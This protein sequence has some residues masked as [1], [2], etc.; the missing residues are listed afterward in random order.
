MRLAFDM[1]SVLQTALK[2]GIDPEGSQVEHNGK[3]VQINTAAY[4]YE[5]AINL[6][7]KA[8]EDTGCVP[9]D[10]ILVF[11]GKD[12]KRRRVM[13]DPTYKANRGK[14]PPEE[15]IQFNSLKDMM[16][17][18]WRKLGAICV[19]QDGV[20]G[21]DVLGWLAKH[22]EEDLTIVTNDGDMS[23]LNGVN[24]HG[25]NILVRLNKVTGLNKYGDFDFKL[26]T[27]YKALVGD[28]NDG[29]KGVVGFGDAAWLDL[30][31]KYGDDGCFELMA[32]IGAGKRDE[33]AQIAHDNK[34]KLLTKITDQWDAATKCLKLTKLHPEWVHTPRVQLVWEPGF[35]HGEVN[36]ER[37]RKWAAKKFLV[38]ADNYEEMYE[39]LAKRMAISR[40]PAFDIESSQP[41]ESDEWLAAQGK[42]DGVD[43]LGHVLTG[44]SITFGR[45]SQN[46]YYVCV[47]HK[48]TKNVTMSQ[49]RKMIELQFSRNVVIQN[50]FFELSV[51]HGAQ[52]EDGTY[53]RDHWKKYGERGFIP[54]I[55]DTKLEGSYVNENM[56]LGLKDRSKFYLGYEQKTYEETVTKIIDGVPVKHKMNELTGEEV[57]DYGADDTM[58]TSGL[59]NF[60]K[61]HMQLDHHW[62]V[63]L[64]TEI[65]A[66]YI[67]AKSFV[68]GMPVSI[69]VSKRL[70]KKDD[71]VYEESWGIVRKYLIEKGWDGTVPPVFTSELT[72]KDI[73]FAY[74]I[75]TGQEDDDEDEENE[76][77][78]KVE[79][80]VKPKDAFLSTK[81]R[82]PAKLVALL[83][84]VGQEDLAKLVTQALSGKP[85]ALTE[86]V[87]SRFTGEPK[88][89]FSPK[90]LGNL[91]Y[92]VMGLPIRLRGK[93]TPIMKSKGITEG[94]PKANELAIK[95]AIRDG[96]DE[97]KAV[98][99]ALIKMKMVMTRRSLYYSKYPNF[100]HW[101]TGR[102]HGSHNQCAT[103]TRRA[104]ES[105]PNKTQLPKNEKVEG[106]KPEYRQV[107]VPHKKRAVIVS[108]DF[109]QQELKIIADYSQDPNMLA[110]YVGDNKKDMHILTASGI[111]KKKFPK[112]EWTY[113]KFVAEYGDSNHSNYQFLKKWRGTGKTVNFATEY[114]AEAEKVSQ[115]MMVDEEEAQTYIDAKR[116]IFARAEKWKEEVKDQA[117]VDG[118]VRTKL[119]AVRHLAE[120]LN[121]EDRYIASKAERQAVNFKIQSSGAEM[122]KKAEGRMWRSSLL[123]DF[124]CVYIGPV[125]DEVVWSV[126]L[127]Q[128]LE[129]AKVA[130]PCMVVKYADM[131]VPVT[132]SISF[133][134]DFGRQI[135]VGALVD[136][137][138]FAEGREKLTKMLEAA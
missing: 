98:L 137:K 68:D 19:S 24:E 18:T 111:L 28:S 99:E 115:T 39:G 87:Q 36:D 62:Q 71:G 63:Y 74:A 58:T 57:F 122:T 110:C 104:S 88:L 49:A 11:E 119:G 138:A 6:M 117:K 77:G 96:N 103:N 100:V 116:E 69:A 17:D 41:V 1:S 113:E 90:Q 134:P 20:E 107:I 55:R 12:S 109:E 130:H 105:A 132:S 10:C 48:D 3:M 108:M 56:K 79:K 38:T 23:V 89:K 43:Q 80:P 25:A 21:D 91:L 82:T 81:V 30:N 125:H 120:L 118:I 50:T 128:L 85:A 133:G 73:K 4:G 94:N 101:K 27:L 2:A 129:W 7:V 131:E 46:T 86:Y 54:N 34:C 26:I 67:H 8:L 47:D 59:H 114:G 53:W 76:D 123:D 60:Y 22:V 75:V 9:S 83:E 78:E 136:E 31:F 32:L 52:D 14:G 15:Y 72:A 33:V 64:D 126:D 5:N 13:I 35:V 40:D 121:S 97:Q 106:Q 45:N 127:D 84:S 42:D 37:L 61:L 112:D 124:D 95:Y 102:V 65:D 93:V 29:I 92:T 70:E 44:F 135:E 16:K 66:A 51:L